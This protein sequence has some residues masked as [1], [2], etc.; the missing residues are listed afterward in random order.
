MLLVL[1]FAEIACSR[2]NAGGAGGGGIMMVPFALTATGS[3]ASYWCG[4][5]LAMAAQCLDTQRW[6]GTC[7]APSLRSCLKHRGPL[8]HRMTN[9][10]SSERGPFSPEQDRFFSERDG[11]EQEPFQAQVSQ[12]QVWYQTDLLVK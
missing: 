12:A 7:D 11:F 6:I 10:S 1:Q 9:R 5:V 4:I 3:G 8:H 2:S